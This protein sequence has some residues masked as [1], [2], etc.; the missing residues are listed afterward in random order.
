MT[1]LTLEK[2]KINERLDT[3]QKS[4]DALIVTV[5]KQNGRIGKLEDWRA[6]LLGIG[7]VLVILVVPIFLHMVTDF[8]GGR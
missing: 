2:L 5:Q 7:T 3:L 1:Q 6:Y 4:V 8:M